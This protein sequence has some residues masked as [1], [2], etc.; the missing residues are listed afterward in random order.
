MSAQNIIKET[1]IMCSFSVLPDPRKSRNQL[2]SL[3]DI[4]TLAILGILCGVDIELKLL[5]GVIVIRIGYI[6]LVSE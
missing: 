2:Y 4:V 5:Y 6:S 3:F 1:S